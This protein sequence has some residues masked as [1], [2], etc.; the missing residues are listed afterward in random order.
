MKLFKGTKLYSIFT[1]TCPVCHTGKMYQNPNPYII[2]E[3]LKMKERCTHCNT[4]FKIEPSFFYGAMYVSYP[5]G[6]IF[7]GIAFLIAFF[8]LG[9]G[10]LQILVVIFITMLLLLPVVVRLSRNIWINFFLKF[11]KEKAL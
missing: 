8:V 11:D 5:V 2:S 3:T 6:L 9:L 1:S 10:K 7:A 4:K